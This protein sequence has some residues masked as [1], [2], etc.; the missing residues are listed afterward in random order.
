MGKI[1]R[2]S[3]EIKNPVAVVFSNSIYFSI[4]AYLRVHPISVQEYTPRRVSY[5][6]YYLLRIGWRKVFLSFFFPLQV[7]SPIVNMINRTVHFVVE[8]FL[9]N[10][11]VAF[12]V[13]LII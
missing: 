13:I 9:I 3:S 12:H 6:N 4:K 10:L 7:D 11:R 5:S 1:F 8:I 2:N